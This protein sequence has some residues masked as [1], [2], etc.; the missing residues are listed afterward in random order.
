M[1]NQGFFFNPH[2]LR[3]EGGTSVEV[4]VVVLVVAHDVREEAEDFRSR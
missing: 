3:G 1:L 2:L 4:R